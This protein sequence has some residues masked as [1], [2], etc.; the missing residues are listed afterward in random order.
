M[1]NRATKVW[2]EKMLRLVGKVML[3]LV[4]SIGGQKETEEQKI[5]RLKALIEDN[6]EKN[7]EEERLRLEE[8]AKK[9]MHS[10]N[11]FLQTGKMLALE[12]MN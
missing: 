5:K 4:S 6:D 10:T 8:D 11:C 2:I 1:K 3:D 7:D 9:E 12:V